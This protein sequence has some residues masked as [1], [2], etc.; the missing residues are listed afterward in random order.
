MVVLDTPGDVHSLQIPPHYR[1]QIRRGSETARPEGRGLGR[2]G[3]TYQQG[4]HLVYQRPVLLPYLVF[5]MCPTNDTSAPLEE[6][7]KWGT[8]YIVNL[9]FKTY[10][11]LNAITLSKN[12]LRA[13]HATT[14][15]MPALKDFPKSH[16]VT[17]KYYVGVISFLEE[18]YTKAEE[19]L[20]AA[21]YLCH[22]D[23]IRNQEL[24]LTY[25]I[26]THLLTT[27][28]LPTPALLARYPR[29]QTLFA[30]LCTT[31][32]SGNLRA[33]DAALSNGEAEF[34]KRRIY[35]TLE[36]GRDIAMRNLFRKVYIL[37]DKNT[38]IPV[39]TFQVAMGCAV[40]GEGGERVEVE[41]EEVECLLAGLVYK[42]LIK[43]YISREKQMVVLSGSKAFPGTGV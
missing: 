12:I 8:Y 23:A 19:N 2:C 28:T 14:G 30:P 18:D 29:L 35:L 24:I 5:L 11:K 3:T 9:L 26:P 37:G 1:D 43:G 7:R 21:F 16:I 36:R 34:V 4:V 22:R 6:S 15:D 40:D 41:V 39:R 38:R 10:F 32:K 42:G 31:I 13:L 27:H 33:F 20:T 17:F 25:L